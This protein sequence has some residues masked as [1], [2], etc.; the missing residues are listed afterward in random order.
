MTRR[1]AP[2]PLR[3]MTGPV[4]R[5]GAPKHTLPSLPRPAFHPPVRISKG[6]V[7]RE[8]AHALVMPEPDAFARTLPIAPLRSPTSA[9]SGST[10]GCTSR[11][12]SESTRSRRSSSPPFAED[13]RVRGPWEKHTRA[14]ELGIDIS[15]VV[16]PPGPVAIN[17]VPVW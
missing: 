1:P 6:P 2:T 12:S 3:L 16:V 4:P 11:S 7:P 17:P 10:D 5:R 15:T 14:F 8:R 13:L 9:R